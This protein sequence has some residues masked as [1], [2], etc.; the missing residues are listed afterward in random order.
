M[1]S[2]STTHCIKK[3]LPSIVAHT[4]DPS[5][6]EAEAEA[7]ADAGGLEIWSQSML[8]NGTLVSFPHLQKRGLLRKNSAEVER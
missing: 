5:T 3:E 6:Q 1:E 4:C 8:K 7:E 2:L